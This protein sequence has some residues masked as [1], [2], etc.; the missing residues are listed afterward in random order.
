MALSNS[1]ISVAMVKAELGAASNDVGQLCTHPNVNKWSKNKPISSNKLTVLTSADRLESDYG[2]VPPSPQTSYTPV[3]SQ[4]WIYNR[5]TGG[6][7]SPY[8]LGDFGGY[9]HSATP[10]ASLEGDITINRTMTS[11]RP[12][13]LTMRRYGT[14]TLLGVDDYSKAGGISSGY[15]A[16]VFVKN[17]VEYIQSAKGTL[18]S[19]AYQIELDLTK[20]PFDTDET[21]QVYHVIINEKVDPIALRSTR[22][23][24]YRSLPTA[25]NISNLTTIQVTSGLG[26]DLLVEKI[27]SEAHFDDLMY[28]NIGP[29]ASPTGYSFPSDGGAWFKISLYNLSSDPIVVPLTGWD[30]NVTP[31]YWGDNSDYLPATVYDGNFNSVSSVTV[32]PAGGSSVIYIGSDIVLHGGVSYLPSTKDFY[33]TVNFRYN[34][35]LMTSQGI[36]FVMNQS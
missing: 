10:I 29:F 17:G 33:G 30:M 34:A 11:I 13:I 22:S 20:A 28:M 25:D 14:D 9:E 26:I 24:G 12:L 35:T 3:Y 32:P 5:P 15:Y 16:A 23:L 4:N 27:A 7:N 18:G 31:N 8:R 6:I 21:I 2:L 1:N 36:R 19:G